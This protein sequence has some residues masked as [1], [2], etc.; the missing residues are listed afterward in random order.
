MTDLLDVK[1][2]SLEFEVRG[3]RIPVLDRLSFRVRAGTTVALVGESGSGKSVTAQAIMGILPKSAHISGGQILLAD[4]ATGKTLD[5]ASLDPDSP[6]FREV[7]G[8]RISM[9]FQEPMLSLS[10]VHTVGDQVSEALFLHHRVDQA[11][12]INLTANMLRLVGFPDPQAALRMYPFELSGGLRQRA[13]IAM[14]LI[15]RPA[16]LIAD[17][18]TTA[19]DVTIQAQI[20]ALLKD[21]QT[22]LQMAVL[23]ITHD[24]GVVANLADEVVVLYRGRR[25][26]YGGAQRHLRTPRPPLSA[27]PAPRGAA[28]RHETAASGSYR[29]ARSTTRPAR[30]CATSRSGRPTPPTCT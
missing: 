24:L 17:E 13:M 6:R 30:C 1:D 10:P 23:M 18:P 16:L 26:E 12:G 22:R 9:I 20:L 29:S 11:E 21:L 25:T 15:C 8:A 2:L 14:A 7:R 5:L 4:A 27:R 19:L 28:L 3:A